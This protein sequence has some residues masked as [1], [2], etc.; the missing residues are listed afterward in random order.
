MPAETSQTLEQ[1]LHSRISE[2]TASDRPKEIID[3]HVEK[4]FTSVV[5]DAFRSYGD[6][7]KAV[8]EA[9]QA[10]MPGNVSDMMELTRYNNLIANAMKEKWE[11]SGVEADMVRR[12]HEAIDEVISEMQMPELVSLRSLLEAFA[13]ENAEEA[14]QEGWEAPRIDIDESDTAGFVRIYFDKDPGESRYSSR[15]AFSLANMI[16]IHNRNDERIDGHEVGEVYVAQVDNDIMGKKMGVWTSNWE[17]QMVALYY[18]GAKLI[19]DCD[20][21]DISY[22]FHD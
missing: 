1:L 13:K 3:Q 19:I 6:M 14:M 15:S 4:M 5:D 22:P 2:F 16:G 20:A 9:L 18:G 7:G 21:D 11:E 17:K 10:A 8:K 12:T